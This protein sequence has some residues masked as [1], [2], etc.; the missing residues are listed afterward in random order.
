ME[1]SF[2]PLRSQFL[3]LALK[4]PPLSAMTLKT[5]DFGKLERDYYPLPQNV[6]RCEVYK[7]RC[8]FAW[9]K[10]IGL[11]EPSDKSSRLH[12]A[13]PYPRSLETLGKFPGHYTKT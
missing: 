7:P 6:R 10:K 4:L 8:A 1:T 12:Q 2:L 13:A 9:K 11:F 5:I 3:S